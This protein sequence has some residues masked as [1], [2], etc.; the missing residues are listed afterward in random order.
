[1]QMEMTKKK[2]LAIL[3]SDKVDFKTKLLKKDAEGHYIMIKG[4]HYTRRE[5]YTH[6]PICTQYKS[7]QIHETTGIRKNWQEYNNNSKKL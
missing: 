1:M 3:I 7:S 6:Q 2:G 5:H 4:E